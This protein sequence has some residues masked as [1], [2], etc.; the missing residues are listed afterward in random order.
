M[1]KSPISHNKDKSNFS[2]II[3]GAEAVLEYRI[4]DAG[5][6][7]DFYRTYVPPEARGKGLAEALVHEG[8]KW[9]KEQQYSIK[10]SCW[11]VQRFLD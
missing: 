2:S 3:S 10:A 1:S 6:T 7:V 8:L 4:E 9:A 11:Y 5:A